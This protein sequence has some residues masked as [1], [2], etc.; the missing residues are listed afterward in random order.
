MDPLPPDF[1]KTVSDFYGGRCGNCGSTERCRAV[2]VRPE[3]VGGRRVLTNAAYLCR[4]CE[5]APAADDRGTRRTLVNLWM[6]AALHQRIHREAAGDGGG[7]SISA[8]ARHLVALYLEGPPERF[9]DLALY[10]DNG[11]D[12]RLFVWLDGDQ[13]E[14]FKTRIRAQGLTV[15]TALIGLF[16]LSPTAIP[17]EPIP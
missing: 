13:Y 16:L 17:T 10:Q 8:R 1:T 7:V 2:L 9:D 4:A 14:A 12:T 6:S 11:T 5:L 3:A 15:T